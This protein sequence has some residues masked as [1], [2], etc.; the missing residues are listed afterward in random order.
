MLGHI[1]FCIFVVRVNIKVDL[2]MP[3]CPAVF[4]NPAFVRIGMAKA[5]YMYFVRKSS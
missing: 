3:V 2:S 4:F 1:T 5:K